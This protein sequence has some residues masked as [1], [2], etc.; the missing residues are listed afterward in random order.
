MK[1][2]DA[3]TGYILDARARRLSEHTIADYSYAFQKLSAF[4]GDVQIEQVT[5]EQIKEFLGSLPV[6]NKTVLNIHTALS[7][8]WRW[9]QEEGIVSENIVRQIRPPK[10]EQPDIVPFTREEVKA[11]LNAV[12]RSAVYRRP[13]KGPS[14]HALP[15]PERNRAILLVLLDTGIRASE[16]CGLK[17]RDLNLKHRRLHIYGKGAKER[18]VIFSATT[19]KAVWRYLRTRPDARLNEPLFATK[20]GYPLDRAGLYHLLQRIG[21]RAGVPNVYPHRFR[22]TFAINFLRNGG[23]AFTLQ[24]LLGHSTMDMVRRYLRIVEADLENAHQVASPVENWRL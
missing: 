24:M 8:L 17:I 19:G 23:N 10:P 21:N 7:A 12:H 11:M 20:R 6:S 14:D 5:V 22:H 15:M 13:G 9:A 18:T 3:F 16:L 1:L 2:S 4:L